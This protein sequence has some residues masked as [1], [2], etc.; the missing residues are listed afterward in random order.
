MPAV[1][2]LEERRAYEELYRIGATSFVGRE[3]TAVVLVGSHPAEEITGWVREH[4]V[5]YIVM[6]TH[7]HG[8]MRHLIAGSVTEAVIRA[9]LAP[10]IAVRPLA[11]PESP[12]MAR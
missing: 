4:P 1:V 10:V 7:G 12:S 6:A 5:D 8:G 3:T 9:G 11:V 2:D